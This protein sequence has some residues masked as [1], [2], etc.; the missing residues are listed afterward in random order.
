MLKN[1][2]KTLAVKS[3]K[4]TAEEIP[5]GKLQ[6]SRNNHDENI[7]ISYFI[8][9]SILIIISF[10]IKNFKLNFMLSISNKPLELM[11]DRIRLGKSNK[12]LKME[13]FYDQMLINEN[14]HLQRTLVA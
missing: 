12:F 9:I 3:T 6:F 1:T 14:G 4:K 10:G 13:N 8:F 11:L 2:Q 5:Q 7:Q